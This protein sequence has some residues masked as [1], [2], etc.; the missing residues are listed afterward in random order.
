MELLFQLQVFNVIYVRVKSRFPYSCGNTAIRVTTII[1]NMAAPLRSVFVRTFSQNLSTVDCSM[2]NVR[3]VRRINLFGMRTAYRNVHAKRV[4]GLYR[5]GMYVGAGMCV[6]GGAS[7]IFYFSN[8]PVLTSSL[9][10]AKSASPDQ[11]AKPT[12]MV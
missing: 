12:R 10:A 11:N 3:S 7:A 2:L 4:P 6:V 8:T 5:V 1:D 9:A